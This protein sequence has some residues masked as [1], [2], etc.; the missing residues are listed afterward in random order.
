MGRRRRLEPGVFAS[1]SSAYSRP[2]L[3][4]RSIPRDLP[5]R[6][7]RPREAEHRDCPPCGGDQPLSHEGRR[8]GMDGAKST[9]RAGR[10]GLPH[11]DLARFS[12]I[13][14]QRNC[15]G[16]S[17]AHPG[18]SRDPELRTPAMPPWIPACAGMS[19]ARCV[20]GPWVPGLRFAAPGM[21]RGWVRLAPLRLARKSAQST[22]PAFGGG[23]KAPVRLPPHA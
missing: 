2:W 4:P 17:P 12:C 14:I 22:S 16:L 21:T 20:G 1:R 19:G 11:K 8:V 6:S 7:H 15:V 23:G 13:W 3:R 10:E 5:A 9:M 18:A